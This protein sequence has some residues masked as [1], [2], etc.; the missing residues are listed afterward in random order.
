M[1][2]DFAMMIFRNTG[3]ISYGLDEARAGGIM[4]ASRDSQVQTQVDRD[5]FPPVP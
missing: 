5:P 4:E 2:M 1:D 3:D